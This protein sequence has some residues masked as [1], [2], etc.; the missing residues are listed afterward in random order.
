MESLIP[1]TTS[2]ALVDCVDSAFHWFELCIPFTELNLT[3]LLP[4][5]RKGP[6]VSQ[7]WP[8]AY[9]SPAFLRSV[10]YAPFSWI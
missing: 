8:E 4:V 2:G 6:G 1:F 5:Q 9:R 7:R 3:R 10:W